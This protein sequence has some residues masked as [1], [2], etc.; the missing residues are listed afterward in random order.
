[1][2]LNPGSLR[3]SRDGRAPSY[4]LLTLTPEQVRAQ[5]VFFWRNRNQK[6]GISG[7]EQRMV[8]HVQLFS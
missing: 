5:I 7:S 2:L 3:Y 6:N 8:G 4:A 1:M